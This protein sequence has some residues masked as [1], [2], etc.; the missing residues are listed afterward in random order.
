MYV[1][2]NDRD[3]LFLDDVES[4]LAEFMGQNLAIHGFQQAGS[5]AAVYFDR[6]LDDRPG[7]LVNVHGVVRFKKKKM[8]R[9]GAEIAESRDSE[10]MASGR[11]LSLRPLL[12]DLCACA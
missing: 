1:V 4:F 6:T 9:R 10:V 12:R 5:E 8:S 7:D 11:Q 2:P 3:G